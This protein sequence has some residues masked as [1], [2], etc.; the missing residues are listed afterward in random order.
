MAAREGQ[1]SVAWQDEHNGAGLPAVDN[2]DCDVS[3]NP[4]GL[5]NAY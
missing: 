4:G 3:M 2:G 1:P 5:P